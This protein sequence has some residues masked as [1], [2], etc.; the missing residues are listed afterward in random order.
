MTEAEKK[1]LEE[2]FNRCVKASED[3]PTFKSLAESVKDVNDFNSDDY[4]KNSFSFTGV[5][6]S[7]TAASLAVSGVSISLTLGCVK[8]RGLF[9]TVE[10]FEWVKVCNSSS[11]EGN[12]G[13]LNAFEQTLCVSLLP[14]TMA[15]IVIKA[16]ANKKSASATMRALLK[17]NVN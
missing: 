7:A 4:A 9:A 13:K 12:A 15:Y 5:S 17:L 11:Y 10:G 1:E 16:I 2:E 6:A 14:I 8:A 3:L